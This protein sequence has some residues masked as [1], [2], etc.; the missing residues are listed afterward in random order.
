MIRCIPLALAAVAAFTFLAGDDA[1]RAAG[2]RGYDKVIPSVGGGENNAQN[3]DI[4][5]NLGEIVSRDYTFV[6]G[7]GVKVSV[8]QVLDQGKPVIVTMGYFQCPLLCNLVHEGL[9]KAIKASGLKLG[10]D[11]NALAISVD[12]NEKLKSANTNQRMLLRN[13]G[14]SK[15]QGADSG[16]PFVMPVAGST[17]ENSA[18]KAMSDQLGFRYFYDAASKQFAHAAVAF[19]LT[20][21]GKISRYVYGVDFNPQTLRMAVVEAGGGRVGTTIDRVLLSCFKY[22]PMSR[23]YTP[24]VSGFVRIGAGLSGLALFTLL[25]VLWW[26]EIQM[27]KHPVGRTA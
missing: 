27:R 10:Q 4:I 26:K 21:T 18:A 1:A 12:P 24:F 6:D 14:A 3:I 13:L 9:V 2:Y 20:P 15:H 11:F 5:E 16:W 17:L 25:G 19:I 23:K 22:D 7:Y 8:G